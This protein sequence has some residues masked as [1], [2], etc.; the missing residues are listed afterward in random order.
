MY[1]SLSEEARTCGTNPAANPCTKTD[2]LCIWMEAADAELWPVCTLKGV[3]SINCVLSDMN[4]LPL[5]ELL[6]A[7][8]E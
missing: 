1:D 8:N 4:T 7:T 3:S 5:L 6:Y 2:Q